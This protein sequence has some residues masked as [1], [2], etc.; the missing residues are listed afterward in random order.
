MLGGSNTPA[1][2]TLNPSSP[3]GL[4]TTQAMLMVGHDPM[5][6]VDRVQRLLCLTS[7]VSG[8]SQI[9]LSTG[10][11]VKITMKPQTLLKI[12]QI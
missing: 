12:V 3:S 11:Q 8:E 5:V 9:C 7:F 2:Q 6:L 10:C 4:R 1:F